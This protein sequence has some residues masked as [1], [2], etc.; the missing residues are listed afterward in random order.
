MLLTVEFGHPARLTLLELRDVPLDRLRPV[1]NHLSRADLGGQFGLAEVLVV[2]LL[3][4]PSAHHPPGPCDVRGDP[5]LQGSDLP[6]QIGS[7][8]PGQRQLRRVRDPRFRLSSGRYQVE[9]G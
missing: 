4:Q 8:R 3:R 5:L 7:R 2:D 9:L 6:G 1:P